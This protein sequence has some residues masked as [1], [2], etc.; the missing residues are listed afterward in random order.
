MPPAIEILGSDKGPTGEINLTGRIENDHIEPQGFTNFAVIVENNAG[1]N[2]SDYIVF[3]QRTVGELMV[4]PGHAL[5]AELVAGK[6]EECN[7]LVYNPSSDEQASFTF[8]IR[9]R[10]NSHLGV[11]NREWKFVIPPPQ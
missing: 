1:I 11:I 7:F 3:V 6:T 2:I 9:T 8:R 10:Y 5:I 4:Y